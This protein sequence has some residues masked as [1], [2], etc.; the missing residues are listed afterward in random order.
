MARKSKKEEMQDLE[1]NDEPA[2]V[3][4]PKTV[5]IYTYVGRGESPPHFTNFMGLQNFTRGVATEVTNPTVLAKVAINPC[6]V[7][8]AVDMD[9]LHNHDEAAKQEA[10]KRRAAD[11]KANAAYMKKHKTE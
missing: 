7:E 3:R 10:D 8:G 11:L 5:A 9:D 1:V 2:E 4:D 6:F